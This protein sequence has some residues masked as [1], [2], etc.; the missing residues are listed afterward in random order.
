[1]T[2]SKVVLIS[3]ASRGI[4]KSLV[5]FYLSH[6]G[7]V[8]VAGVRDPAKSQDTLKELPAA[9]SS[10]LI[11]VKLDSGSSVDADNA[12]SHLQSEHG[13]SHI[14][15]TI[16][17][18][19]ICDHL[20]PISSMVVN[21]LSRHIDTNTY[22]VLRLFQATWPMLQQS[23][24][25]KFVCISSQLGSIL[26]AASNAQYTAAYGVSKAAV[27]FLISKIGAENENLIAFS[28]DPGFVQTDMGNRGAQFAGLEQAPNT[29]VESV[30][31]IASE[32]ELA[33]RDRC[34]GHFRS[35]DGK[36]IPW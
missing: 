7:F 33:T 16:T 4:G 5:G 22:G 2:S 27:N 19:G 36:E 35:H 14:D 24:M 15:I 3:G 23:P 31:G 21:E 17:N 11:I 28:V 18:A 9:T 20:L 13:I 34:N 10:S 6:P 26:S 12:V 25:P 8:V 30:E 32:V 29:L 1:M